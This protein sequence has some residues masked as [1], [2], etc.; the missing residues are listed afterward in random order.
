MHVAIADDGLTI[1]SADGHE[2]FFH[3]IWLRDN[4]RCTQCGEPSIGR[5]TLRLTQIAADVSAISAE[6]EAGATLRIRWSD[7]HESSF[8]AE[9][10][11]AHCYDDA[12]RRRRVFS[13]ALWQDSTR[14]N[15]PTMTFSSVLHDDGAFLEMLHNVRDSGICFIGDAP[16]CPGTL[17]PLARKIGPPQENNFGR[18]QDLVVDHSKR[19]I[20]NDVNELKP[21]T[22]EPY[23]ASPPGLLLFHCVET[24]VDGAGSSIFLD[25]FEIAEILKHEDP[26]GF[27]ALVNNRQP[28]RRYF[29]DDVDLIAQFPIIAIDEFNNITGI[30]INDRVAAP[31]SI[32][33]GQVPAYYKGLRRFLE[34]AEDPQRMIQR[35][36]SPGDI[37]VFDNHRVLHGRTTL[38]M[39]G[40][41][42]LQWIQVER[43]DFHSALRI[44]ADRLG[45]ERDALPLLRG[46]YA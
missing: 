9:W 20:A 8:S 23:R 45:L 38:T 22:D 29:S 40:R 41:R 13:P 28:F 25:G 44:T 33:P 36:L 27:M 5:R 30:R 2:R 26:E 10:L 4:C 17:E 1:T 42:W 39:K 21:H 15:P 12:A 24:D 43:G 11:Q 6:I 35:T 46:A 31:L 34:L 16:P 18:V 19:S 14:A 32:P 3:H 37:V 7:C